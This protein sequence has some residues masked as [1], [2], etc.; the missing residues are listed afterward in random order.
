MMPTL[1][2]N[3]STARIRQRRGVRGINIRQLG[4][5]VGR[6]VGDEAILD[7]VG[8]AAVP[9][10]VLFIAHGELGGGARA[11]EIGRFRQGLYAGREILDSLAMVAQKLINAAALVIGIDIGFDG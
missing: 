10:G 4:L 5:V 7:A 9:S 1:D 3:T 6:G 11:I 2:P 8:A